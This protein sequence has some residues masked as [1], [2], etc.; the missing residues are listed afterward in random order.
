ML[1]DS[2]GEIAVRFAREIGESA[3]RTGS[4]KVP[5]IKLP[6]VFEKK[7]G[8][9]VTV[10]TFPELTLRGCIGIPEPVYT[11]RQALL[12]SAVDAVLSDPRFEPVEE[13]ELD[14]IVF[15]LSI[16]SPPELIESRSRWDIPGS[17][18]VGKHGIIVERGRF[19]GLLLPQVAVDEKW[20]SEEFL[21]MTCWKAGIPEDS[22]HDPRVNVYRFEGE[23]FGEEKPRGKVVRRVLR[24]E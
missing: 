17:V 2:E 6:P 20:E 16:L 13:G 7:A 18:E 11:L 8:A 10:Q 4:Y 9:F 15:E 3:V 23:I 19:R 24:K 1:T 14:A 12:N 5:E 21:R 22:W